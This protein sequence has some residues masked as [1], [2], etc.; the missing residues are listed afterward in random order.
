MTI[1]QS[2][3]AALAAVL[4][5]SHA[6]EL[7]PRPTWPAITF[8]V[9]TT[10]EDTWVMGGGYDQHVVTVVTLA[11]TVAAIDG[12]KP[13]I[14]AALSALSGYM[15]DEDHGDAEYEDDPNVYAYFQNFRIRTPTL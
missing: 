12:Y 14:K 8:E 11:T 9:D 13:Q 5:N 6:G 3:Y 7:P 2:V 1:K 15:A 10:P 4:A